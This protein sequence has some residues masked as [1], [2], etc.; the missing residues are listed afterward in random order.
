MGRQV[1]LRDI[2]PTPQE[3]VDAAMR[4]TINAEMFRGEYE[5]GFRGRQ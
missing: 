4:A 5:K 3:E 1:Y 2:W